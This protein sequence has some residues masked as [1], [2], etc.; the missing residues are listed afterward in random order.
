MRREWLPKQSVDAREIP[1]MARSTCKDFS[2]VA[3]SI[4][5]EENSDDSSLSQT[6]G[7]PVFRSLC[8]NWCGPLAQRW[9]RGEDA[10]LLVSGGMG[11]D[12]R[13]DTSGG[14]RRARVGESWTTVADQ[15]EKT[16]RSGTNGSRNQRKSHPLCD[17]EVGPC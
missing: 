8:G 5:E 13:G 12:G 3:D 16:G 11:C 7:R 1:A 17:H 6:A 4:S 9:N 10:R 2:F 15:A 14:H